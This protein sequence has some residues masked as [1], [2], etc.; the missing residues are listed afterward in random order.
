MDAAARGA[1]RRAGP[2]GR[3]AATGG[4]VYPGDYMASVADGVV[5]RLQPLR[6]FVCRHEQ[7]APKAGGFED[8]LTE[9]G[10][11]AAE[12]DMVQKVRDIANLRAIY[13]SP[14]KRCLQTIA[15]F[16]RGA[17]DTTLAIKVDYSLYEHP[18]PHPDD[19]FPVLSDE[20]CAQYPLDP[21]YTSIFTTEDIRRTGNRTGPQLRRRL[22]PFLKRIAVRHA[23]EATNL[24]VPQSI[25]LVTHQTCC[26]QLIGLDQGA[27][28]HYLDDAYRNPELMNFPMGSI[29]ELKNIL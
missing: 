6:V 10:L 13:S 11:R 26:H 9:E 8:G 12:T 4:S 24:G 18:S 27:S 2:G 25:L 3:A 20:A 17:G 29:Y 21:S 19:T 15:P 28:V 7:R 16:V 14:F 1:A 22:V 23:N 5:P